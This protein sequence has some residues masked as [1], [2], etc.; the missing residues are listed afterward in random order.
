MSIPIDREVSV[1]DSSHCDIGIESCHESKDRLLIALSLVNAGLMIALVL[2][3]VMVASQL[4]VAPSDVLQE[5]SKVRQEIEEVRKEIPTSV[6]IESMI[7]N[8]APWGKVREDWEEWRGV[9]EA[10]LMRL[11]VGQEKRFNR[12]EEQLE[13][14]GKRMD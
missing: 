3:L 10:R 2:V 6:A 11:E 1:P 5:V 12:I 9:Q 4:R 7:Q 8:T 13:A 14:L